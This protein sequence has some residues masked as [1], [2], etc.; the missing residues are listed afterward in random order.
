MTVSSQRF[1]EVI[2][3]AITVALQAFSHSIRPLDFSFCP[4]QIGVIGRLV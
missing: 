3:L 2:M 4:L 1:N